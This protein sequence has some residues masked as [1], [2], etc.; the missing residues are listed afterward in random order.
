MNKLSAPRCSAAL[1]SLGL[2]LAAL[3]QARGAVTIAN[4][5]QSPY[6]IVIA[7]NALPSERYAAE[8][9]QRYL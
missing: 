1:L 3:F 2:T 5:G 4:K 6:R 8:E 7:T 9:L